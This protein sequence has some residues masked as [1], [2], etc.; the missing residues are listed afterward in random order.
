MKIDLKMIYEYFLRVLEYLGILRIIID[1]GNGEIR[2]MEVIRLP[3]YLKTMN[4]QREKID[5]KDRLEFFVQRF[6]EKRATHFVKRIHLTLSGSSVIPI[7]LNIPGIPRDKITSVVSWEIEKHLPVK[8]DEAYYSY[9]SFSRVDSKGMVNWNIMAI[10]TKKEELNKYLD[11]FQKLG[12]LTGSISYLP[13][14]LLGILKPDGSHNGKGIII[15]LPNSIFL[16][17]MIDNKIFSFARYDGNYAK[18]NQITIKNII[19]YFSE[20]VQSDFIKRENI[21]LEKILV[22]SS[23]KE[24]AEPL[25]EAITDAINIVTLPADWSY[26]KEVF[27]NEF[28]NFVD[29]DLVSFVY[30]Q[31]MLPKI[32]FSINRFAHIKDTLLRAVTSLLV[33]LDVLTLLFLPVE[34]VSLSEYS[35]IKQARWSTPVD[36]VTN[37][38]VREMANEIKQIDMIKDYKE[39]QMKML[40]K[41]HDAKSF[42]LETSNIKLVLQDI[43]RYI[44]DDVWLN[45]LTITGRNGEMLGG[46][47]TSDGLDHFTAQLSTNSSFIKDVALKKAEMVQVNNK[48]IVQFTITF[49]V[50][51]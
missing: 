8:L 24:Q 39:R 43:S 36:Q 26:Y 42:G 10:S 44:P 40:G 49:G 21:I 19:N 23:D 18:I 50:S 41:I 29:Y 14:H 30:S 20:M 38:K 27:H 48:N 11:C 3:F 5:E 35:M 2:L 13:V 22:L 17:G 15:I 6:L 9:E 12:I 45:N 51:Q 4:L 16:Y 28:Y 37:P 31:F 33:T 25:T 1:I 32:G 7:F 47:L 34:L 46:S